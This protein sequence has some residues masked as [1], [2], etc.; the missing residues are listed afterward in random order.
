M[1][2]Q[3]RIF[4]NT[5]CLL[6]VSASMLA[7]AQDQRK[8][9][10]EVAAVVGSKIIAKS[11]VENQYT[12]YLAE[13]NTP[14]DKIKCKIFEQGFINKLMVDQGILDSVVVSEDQV[15]AELDRKMRYFIAGV[16]S[17]EKFEEYY[18]KSV[19]ELK[20]EYKDLLREQMLTQQIQAKITG[21]VTTTPQEVQ[22][23]YD[24]I[25]QDSL[26]SVGAEVEVAQ[27]IKSAVIS[28]DEMLEVKSRLL[29]I[30]QRILKGEDFATLAVLYS[31]DPGSARKGGELG[32]LGRGELVPQFEAAAFSLKPGEISDV[33]ETQF[34][35]HIIQLIERRGNQINVR[36]VLLKP[37]VSP[38]ALAQ[39]KTT[40]DSA[41]T[42][43]NQNKLSF[44][45]A[46]LKYSDKDDEGA[47]NGGIM[48]NQQS[49]SSRFEISQVDP[50]ILFH[51]DKMTVG[52]ISEPVFFQ[53]PDGKQ[54]YRILQLKSRIEPHKANLRDDYQKIQQAALADKQAKVMNAWIA[55][56]VKSTYILVK[57]PYKNCE[58]I[59]NWLKL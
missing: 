11:D 52:S 57:D 9:I 16:G 35:F 44:E 22:K 54:G 37:K 39:A 32:F 43:I 59:A 48:V 45:Q 6:L 25:P 24:N 19:V 34:G 28:K 5:F 12:R 1:S 4:K 10:D 13:G 27:I 7:Y 56:K 46:A 49:G 14:D 40:I 21:G 26:P 33:V 3:T 55:K 30:K 23:Y 47:K 53:N 41:Y 18:K 58:S 50:G 2:L 42:D 29:E 38:A 51:V 31:E 17:V 8:L 20:A 36:H 15:E